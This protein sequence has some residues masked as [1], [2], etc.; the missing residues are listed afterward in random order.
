[1]IHGNFGNH[2]GAGGDG[3]GWV[4]PHLTGRIDCMKQVLKVV[5]AKLESGETDCLEAVTLAVE[6]LEDEPLFNA[7]QGQ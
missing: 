2:G 5:G 4:K 3:H 6:M 1:M 7:G